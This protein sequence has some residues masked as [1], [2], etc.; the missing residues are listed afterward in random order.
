MSQPRSNGARRLTRSAFFVGA[1]AAGAAGVTLLRDHEIGDGSSGIEAR[2]YQSRFG[3]RGTH[4]GWPKPWL[5]QHYHRDLSV[6][7]GHAVFSLPAG[8]AGSAPEQPM[9]IFLL[10]HECSRATHTVT[11]SVNNA[12]LRPGVL[13]SAASDVDYTAVTWEAAHLVCARYGRAGRI[14]I[15]KAECPRL[16]AGREHNLQ[17]AFKPGSVRARVWP[18]GSASPEW[19]LHSGDTRLAR[20]TVGLVVVHPTDHEPATLRVRTYSLSGTE[21]FSPTSPVV[22]AATTGVTLRRADGC[23][24][25][26]ARVISAFPARVRFYIRRHDGITTALAPQDAHDPPYTGLGQFTVDPGE[27]VRWHAELESLTSGARTSS[28]PQDVHAHHARDRVVLMATSCEQ[29]SGVPP[30]RTYAALAQAAPVRAT[31]MIFQG[32]L[33]YANNIFHSCYLAAPDFFVDRF[34]RMLREQQF[35]DLRARVPTG[36]TQDDHDYGPRNN[37]DRTTYAHWAPPLWN[38]IHADAAPKG[39]Y[40]FRFGDV[41]CL[42]LDVRRYADPVDTANTPTKTRIGEAQFDWMRT[43]L[44]TSDAKLFVVFSAGIFASRYIVDDCWLKGYP[45]EYDRAMRLFIRVQQRGSR[46]LIVSG[47]AHSMRIHYHPYP[48][49]LPR[50]AAA[51][52]EFICSGVRPRVWSGADLG[53]PTV[54]PLRN[55]IGRYGGGMLDIDQP[56]AATRQVTL[57]AISGTIG[58][59][60]DIFPPLVLPFAPAR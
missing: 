6:D 42:T 47:D 32:D 1:L 15:A 17:V 25:V 7:G 28:F 3:A 24:A 34:C 27:R 60:G 48:T 41:H 46:V 8:L 22:V 26:R 59:T 37:A 44:D 53:D 18:T 19:Q 21:H 58:R 35:A 50:P 52:V 51:V 54:D 31:A 20:G 29:F 16:V 56:S 39:Y 13:F 40:D 49:R 5:A 12:S 30:G 43:I 57:R 14:V 45:D 10:D 33:G 11:F 55:V 2:S 38:Q 36:F 4:N 9:P 23:Y